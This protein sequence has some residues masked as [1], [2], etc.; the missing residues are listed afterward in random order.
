MLSDTCADFEADETIPPENRRGLKSSLVYGPNP[1]LRFGPI[2]VSKATRNPFL[3]VPG[4]ASRLVL[5]RAGKFSFCFSE[6]V[7]FLNHSRYVSRR[8][9]AEGDAR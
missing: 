8:S 4:A 6:F 1:S 7:E 5:R 3:D 9:T 2:T